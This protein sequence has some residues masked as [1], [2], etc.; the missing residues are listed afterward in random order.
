[1]KVHYKNNQKMFA[2]VKT[3][4]QKSNTKLRKG[5]YEILQLVSI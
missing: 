1:M 4:L 2:K 3:I 5:K